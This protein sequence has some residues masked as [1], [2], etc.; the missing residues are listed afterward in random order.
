MDTQH[1]SALAVT[2]IRMNIPSKLHTALT[3]L[4]AKFAAMI[5][6]KNVIVTAIS[7]A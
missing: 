1:I 4:Y 6:L 3:A 2:A 7:Q 5:R